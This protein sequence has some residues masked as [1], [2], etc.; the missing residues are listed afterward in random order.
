[1]L[2]LVI[3]VDLQLIFAIKLFGLAL[4]TVTMI[5]IIM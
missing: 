2:L 4:N 5:E 3:I 1:M